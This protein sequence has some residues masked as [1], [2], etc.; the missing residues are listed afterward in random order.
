MCPSQG[1]QVGVG[2]NGDPCARFGNCQSC[3][4][5]SSCGW[6]GAH[7]RCMSGDSSGTP[8]CGGGWAWITNMCPG[9]GQPVYGQP[10]YGQPVYGQPA[11]P[12]DP[13]A[14]YTNCSWCAAQGSCGWCA[15]S[16]RCLSGNGSGSPYC[17]GGWAWTSNMCPSQGIQVGTGWNGDPCGRFGNCQS[18][19][20]QS[21]CGWCGAHNRCMSGDSSGTPYC[22]G[23]WAW[24]TNM[25]PGY[26]QPVYG[27]PVY[28]QPVPAQP[29]Y[30]G[31][32]CGRFGNCQSCAAQ[33]ACGWCGAL[34]RCMAGSG[35]GSPMCPGYWAWTTN[36]CR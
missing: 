11:A 29:V 21:S 5:Q 23:G 15:A 28:G 10:T 1:V 18:C 31:D 16:N 33:G 2:W 34:G 4:A 35:S 27:Q 20:A 26:G 8:Y 19:A 3:A 9:Y 17:Q 12:Y 30:G 32:A 36:M 24:T 7:N 25:C 6:C 13:C 22:G 14:R